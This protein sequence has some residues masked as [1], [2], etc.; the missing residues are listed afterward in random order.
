[1]FVLLD[2]TQYE[3]NGWQNRNKIKGPNGPVLLTVPVRHASFRPIW[4]VEINPQTA[5]QE[6]HWKSLLMC[7]GKA[8]YFRRYAPALE[9][10]LATPWERLAAL[11]VRLIGELARAYGIG[12]RIVR[13][14]CLDVPGMATERL[15]GICRKLGATH[16]LSGEFAA[17]NHLD[18]Q[19]FGD[20]GIELVIQDW[21]CPSYD[22]QFP[23]LGF[24]PELSCLDLLFNEGPNSLDRLMG[25]SPARCQN[26]ATRAGE[27]HFSS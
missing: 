6:K 20:S 19:V 4:E 24:I 13:S 1:V 9:E 12:S 10:I 27:P 26:T 15:I 18:A 7:Y 16:Y 17:G 23:G 2:D 21:S 14:S 3:K 8:P 11:N 5:W 25:R 22:Q